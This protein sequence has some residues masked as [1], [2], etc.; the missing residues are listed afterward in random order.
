MILGPRVKTQMVAVPS[1]KKVG[2]RKNFFLQAQSYWAMLSHLWEKPFS[3]ITCPFLLGERPPEQCTNSG[4]VCSGRWWSWWANEE[5]TI[6][7]FSM[8][9]ASRNPCVSGFYFMHF[10]VSWLAWPCWTVELIN[11]GVV[12]VSTCDSKGNTIWATGN[13]CHH[14]PLACSFSVEIFGSFSKVDGWYGCQLLGTQVLDL[15]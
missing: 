4:C 5:R 9:L 2:R 15:F 14:P 10:F 3:R 12:D 13:K 6:I 11:H 7:I 8:S 1:P